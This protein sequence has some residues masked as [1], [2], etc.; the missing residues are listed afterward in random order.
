MLGQKDRIGVPELYHL[1]LAHQWLV[2][3]YQDSGNPDKAAK[4]TNK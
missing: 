3:L 4:W 2:K 1:N